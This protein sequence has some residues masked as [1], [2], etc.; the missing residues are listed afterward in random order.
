M[1]R[2]ITVVAALALA[3]GI[4]APLADSAQRMWVGF[5]D[6]PSFRWEGDRSATLDR[7]RDADGGV[8][9]ATFEVKAR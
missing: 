8:G 6:D 9:S 3:A 2:M 4:A 1:R 7:V 5:H